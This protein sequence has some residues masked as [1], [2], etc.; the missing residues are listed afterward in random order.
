M[1]TKIIK[2]QPT[3]HRYSQ[4]VKQMLS[5]AMSR[6]GTSSDMNVSNDGKTPITGAQ[7]Q[8]APRNPFAGKTLQSGQAE[9]QIPQPPEPFRNPRSA[10][11]SPAPRGRNI[12]PETV[13][14]HSAGLKRRKPPQ[15]LSPVGGQRYKTM[16]KVAGDSSFYGH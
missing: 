6:I 13:R 4:K 15:D 3:P 7:A 10:A 8:N 11:M 2:H 5:R 12:Q 1:I 14:K 9:Q 16:S